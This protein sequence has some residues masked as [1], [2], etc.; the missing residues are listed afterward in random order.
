MKKVWIASCGIV[1]VFLTLADAPKSAN[2]VAERDVVWDLAKDSFAATQG[3]V[4]KDASGC[5][6]LDGKNAFAIPNSI[7]TDPN[8]FAI[9]I[10]IR[11]NKLEEKD[12]IVLFDKI[13]SE[14]GFKLSCL[15]F[16]RVGSPMTATINGVN[17]NT[18]WWRPQAGKVWKGV[19][20]VRNGLVSVYQ[21]G[22]ARPPISVQVIPNLADI[23]VGREGTMTDV[24]IISLK[25]H[26]NAYYVKGE[27]LSSYSKAFKGGK[28]WMVKC[29]VKPLAGK[30]NVLYYGDSIS[31]GYTDSFE[32]LLDGKAN[33]YHWSGFV[34]SADPQGFPAMPFTSAASVAK[35]D[36]IIFNNGLHS[37]HWTEDKVSDEQI[38]GV[39]RNMIKYFRAGSPKAKLIWVA[40][41][42]HTERA[43]PVK[44]TGDLNPVVLRINRLTAEVM[45][46]EGIP[47]VDL[48]AL[49]IDR[50]ALAGGDGYHWSREAYSMISAELFKSLGL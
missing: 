42:P 5:V 2:V 50:L 34:G 45:K 26:S 6:H 40:T 8:T 32:K 41:T 25:V 7:I 19:F 35:F 30:P 31:G 1:A 29:P 4:V 37:L 20:A 13:V 39:A 16:G 15:N 11:P 3:T 44:A 28:G 9:E 36:Y 10:E 12:N 23:W 18:G 14:T 43:K 46:E 27:T 48:Y 21:N 49:L 22:S 24:D 38:K 47:V 17:Y 33:G